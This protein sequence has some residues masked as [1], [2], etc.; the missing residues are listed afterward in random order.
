MLYSLNM[1]CLICGAELNLSTAVGKASFKCDECLKQSLGFQVGNGATEAIAMFSSF[2]P[3]NECL[4]VMAGSVC[5]VTG[6]LH[7]PDTLHDGYV[8]NGEIK[9]EKSTA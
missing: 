3:L 5:Y 4:Q 8:Y 9:S 2:C 6:A 7:E 1:V